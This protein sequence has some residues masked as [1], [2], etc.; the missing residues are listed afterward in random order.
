[1]AAVR[2]VAA[3]LDRRRSKRMRRGLAGPED[4]RAEDDV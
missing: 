1:M 3:A 4:Q 2:N